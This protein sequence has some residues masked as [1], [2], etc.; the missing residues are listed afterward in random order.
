MA[1]FELFNRYF[2]KYHNELKGT[3][4]LQNDLIYVSNKIISYIESNNIN[5]EYDNDNIILKCPNE[6]YNFLIIFIIV[7]IL[8]DTYGYNINAIDVINIEI[9]H[10]KRFQYLLA[11]FIIV[12]L[13]IMLYFTLTH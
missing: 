10:D 3:I 9:L 8:N 1:F 4:I 13:I 2:N 7:H 11:Y 5:I 6:N 12:Y